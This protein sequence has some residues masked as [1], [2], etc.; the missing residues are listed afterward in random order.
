MRSVPNYQV[1]ISTLVTSVRGASNGKVLVSTKRGA[2]EYE[3]EYDHVILATHGGQALSLLGSDAT[4]LEREILSVFKTSR[5]TA[6]LHSD[7]NV[8]PLPQKL[9]QNN[10]TAVIAVARQ[11]VN[12]GLM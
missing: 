2:V 12:L 7:K 9:S 3:Y 4:K 1:H 8:T 5:N 6:V 11:P 10:L